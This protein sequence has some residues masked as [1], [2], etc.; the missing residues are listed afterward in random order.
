MTLFI[1]LMFHHIDTPIAK[2]PIYYRIENLLQHF[3]K[4]IHGKV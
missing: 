1:L 3:L 4:I 2:L